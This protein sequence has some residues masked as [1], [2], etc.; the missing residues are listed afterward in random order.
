MGDCLAWAGRYP[1]EPPIGADGEYLFI[2][3]YTPDWAEA[4]LSPTRTQQAAGREP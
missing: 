3:A 2:L 4:H 1:K